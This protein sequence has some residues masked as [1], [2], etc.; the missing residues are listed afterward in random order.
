MEYFTPHLLKTVEENVIY[1]MHI[2]AENFIIKLV[3]FKVIH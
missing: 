3:S 2:F 1:I